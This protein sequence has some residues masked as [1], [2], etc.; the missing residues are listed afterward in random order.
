MSKTRNQKREKKVVNNKFKSFIKTYLEYR[1][2][3]TVY[4]QGYVVVPESVH[5]LQKVIR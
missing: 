4:F 3:L 2:Q 5:K 1:K